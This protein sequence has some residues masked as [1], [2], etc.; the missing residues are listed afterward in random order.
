MQYE[1]LLPGKQLDDCAT[2]MIVPPTI[3]APNGKDSVAN[4]ERLKL[5]DFCAN[6]ESLP[7][8]QAAYDYTCSE[9]GRPTL[10]SWMQFLISTDLLHNLKH[11]FLTHRSHHDPIEIFK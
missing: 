10:S 5:K 4:E 3:A 2:P 8:S 11:R 7:T 9:E 1:A 6:S